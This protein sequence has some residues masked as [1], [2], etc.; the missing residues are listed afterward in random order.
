MWRGAWAAML[1]STLIVCLVPMPPHEPPIAHLDKVHH[2]AGYALL[3][4]YAAMLFDTR[5]ALG[6]AML[7]VFALGVLI[8]AL[9]ALVPWRSMDPWDLVA[10]T[11]GIVL[12]ALVAFTP[13][14]RTLH[15][16]DRH[17]A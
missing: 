13:L 11:L 3:V 6:G 15:W 9:Q 10:N 17:F 8:E 2:L 7:G 16:V 1:V 4:A 14:R 12:G 5:R